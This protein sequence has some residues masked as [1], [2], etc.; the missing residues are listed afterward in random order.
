[1]GIRIEHRCF[2]GAVL[3]ISKL[4]ITYSKYWTTSEMLDKFQACYAF[5]NSES[6]IRSLRF[7]AVEILLKKHYNYCF[8][9]LKI[10]N[11]GWTKPPREFGQSK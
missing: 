11:S 2:A 3:N 4:K 10:Y 1:M 8:I 7:E 6:K 9:K 5:Q